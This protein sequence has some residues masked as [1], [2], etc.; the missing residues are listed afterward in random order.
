M[1]WAESLGIGAVGGLF[2]SAA[3][4]RTVDKFLLSH[5]MGTPLR[6]L[7]DAYKNNT[8]I[9]ERL[10]G[11]RRMLAY[12]ALSGLAV[13]LLWSVV[14]RWG[15]SDQQNTARQEGI[16]GTLADVGVSVA[17][18]SI[19]SW[20]HLAWDLV[21]QENFRPL[22]FC[23]GRLPLYEK[24]LFCGMVVLASAALSC[25]FSFFKEGFYP[26]NPES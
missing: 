23:R 20:G 24:A 10:P 8:R 21:I 25:T 1:E 12:G 14:K 5:E 3:Y 6:S 16:K 11:M 22:D 9:L 2:S 15:T 4:L 19:G 17:A 26:Q 18:V 7:I 13:G